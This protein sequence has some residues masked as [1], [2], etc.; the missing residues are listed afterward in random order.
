[1]AYMAPERF[2]KDAEP[3]AQSDIWGFGATLCEILTGKVPFGEDGGQTQAEGKLSMPTIPGASSDV[4]R[5][6]HECL[7]LQPGDRPTAQRIADA[8]RAR[9]YPLKSRKPLWLALLALA[10][11]TIGG[12]VYYLS[13]QESNP[14]V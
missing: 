12:I 6:I 5:L 10:V 8:A 9:Q 14:I 4:Q 7:A 2:Q 13:H 3:M 11:L 1:M